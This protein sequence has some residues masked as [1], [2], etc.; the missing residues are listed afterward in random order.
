MTDLQLAVWTA[1]LS[2]VAAAIA[3]PLYH[4]RTNQPWPIT[5]K[6]GTALGG[7]FLGTFGGALMTTHDF[8]ATYRWLHVVSVAT[9]AIIFC[10]IFQ[11]AMFEMLNH[12]KK[13][14]EAP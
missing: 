14:H 13:K 8:F 11:R 6:V 9:L 5:V 2:L 1:A 4:R 12:E 10:V 7:G 3:G